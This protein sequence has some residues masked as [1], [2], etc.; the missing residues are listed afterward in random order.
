MAQLEIKNLSV[1]YQTRRSLVSALHNVSFSLS[2]GGRL[3]LWGQSGCGKSTIM[4]ALFGLPMDEPGWVT[5][6]A[7]YDSKPVSPPVQRFVKFRAD[8]VILKDNP[9]FYRAHRKLVRPHLGKN[10]R[11]LLQEPIYSFERGQVM[12]RQIKA[13]LK[14]F[15]EQNSNRTSDL[16][17]ELDNTLSRLKLNLR[18]IG[19]HQNLQLSGGE[20]QRI[21]LALNTVGQPRLLFADEPTTAMDDQTR[22]IAIEI[23]GEKIDAQ[24]SSLLIASH[25]RKELLSLADDVLVMCK[26]MV[27]ERFRKTKLRDGQADDFHPYTRRLWFGKFTMDKPGLPDTAIRGGQT[28][29]GCPFVD[30]CPF[31]AKDRSLDKLCRNE[32]PPFF[33]VGEHHTSSCWLNRKTATEETMPGKTSEP[34]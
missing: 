31:P 18:K 3:G 22:E 30:D 27:V 33:K 29:S 34:D 28:V 26:G 5:G 32:R 24:K 16:Y 4:R 20:C 1:I 9:G 12:G 15:A 14:H 10:W 8:G 11:A 25:N 2:S 13:V 19:S 21:Q 23:L 7:W 6:E 17:D